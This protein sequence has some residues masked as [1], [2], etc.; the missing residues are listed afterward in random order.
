MTPVFLVISAP[1]GAGKTTVST[2]LLGANPNLRRVVTCTTRNPRP[3]EQHG[4]D[5]VF[6]DLP[7]F[8][9]RVASGEFL[10]YAEVYGNR[11]GTLK[12][13]VVSLLRS[14][15]DVILSVDVQGVAAIQESAR[16]DAELG[17]SLVTAF[18][19][20][21]N[22]AELEQRLKGRGTDSEEVVARRLATARKEAEQWW[23]FDYIVTSGT[24]EQDQYRMQ[25]ILDAERIRTRRASFSLNS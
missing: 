23:M 11:Y 18:L 7:T 3:G 2:A 13:S 24:R 1:S 14:G 19:C 22:L 20:P 10:E 25:A 6:F 21:S 4:V 5:Y 12:S 8:E 9:Q 15:C 16:R 17:R